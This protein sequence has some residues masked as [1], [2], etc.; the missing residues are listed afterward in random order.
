MKEIREARC[1]FV[2]FKLMIDGKDYLILRRDKDW[3]DLNLIGGHQED[4]DNGSF[5]RTAKREMMEE[6]SGLRGKAEINLVPLTQPIQYGP[7][8][9]ESAKRQSVYH[10]RFYLAELNARPAV[11]NE[12]LATGSMN[13]LVDV[14]NL[15]C[16]IENKDVSAFL[17]LLNEETPG[18]L[19]A[20][21]YTWKSDLAEIIDRQVLNKTFQKQLGLGLH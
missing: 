12:A 13:F 6:L 20:I 21:P 10:L 7:V 9:S 17:G 8:W 11:L 18:G 3:N 1:A 5:E 16:A 2:V 19:D 14:D 15:K 4:K